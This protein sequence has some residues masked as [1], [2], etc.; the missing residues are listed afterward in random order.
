MKYE[1][2]FSRKIVIGLLV[3]VALISLVSAATYVWFFRLTTPVV[4]G[5]QLEFWYSDE[6]LNGAWLRIGESQLMSRPAADLTK[7]VFD[8]KLL[9]N[10]TSLRTAGVRVE[11]RAVDTATEALTDFIGFNV[12]DVGFT[13][14]T[15]AWDHELPAD[16]L[17]TWEIRYVLSS[18]APSGYTGFS[19]DWTVSRFETVVQEEMGFTTID[20]GYHSGHTSPAYYVIYDAETWNDL[21]NQH[22]LFMLDPL[23]PP[24]VDFSKNIVVAAFMGEVSTG[25]YAINIYDVIDTGDSMTVKIEITQPGP[26]CIVTQALTQPYHI[27]EMART[28]KQFTFDVKTTTIE[29]P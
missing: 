22:V 4:Y 6:T 2:K 14:A 20:Q 29:C 23:P 18:E 10:N 8:A 27:I 24:S 3:G 16:S 13:W 5:E 11:I 7:G 1:M 9:V 15:V 21:W 19:I 12:T 25:G 17:T 26:R 28:D